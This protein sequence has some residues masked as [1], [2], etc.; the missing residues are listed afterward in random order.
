MRGL[1]IEALGRGKLD[2]QTTYLTTLKCELKL[3]EDY[4][5]RNF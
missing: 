5:N 3:H 1:F 2:I 4:I